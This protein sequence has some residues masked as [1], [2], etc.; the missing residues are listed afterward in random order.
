[1]ERA[2]GKK[3]RLCRRKRLLGLILSAVMLLVSVPV[4]GTETGAEKKT[5]A[6]CTIFL[7]MCGSNLETNY[8]LA[9]ENIDEI[10]DADI[11]DSTTVI[12]ETGGAERWWSAEWISEDTL[13]RYIVRDGHLELLMDLD[14]A[15]MGNPDT[16]KDFLHDRD[17]L[18]VISVAYDA[19]RQGWMPRSFWKWFR[20]NTND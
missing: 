1:M 10:L 8:G 18:F 16:L 9:T 5:E 14:D 17:H 2:A 12:I 3:G 20:S 7:Y 6:D 15:S 11:P 19:D 4:S 13:Q